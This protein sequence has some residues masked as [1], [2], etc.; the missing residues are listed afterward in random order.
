MSHIRESAEGEV[1]KRAVRFYRDGMFRGPYLLDVDGR[2]IAT[3]LKPSAFRFRLE[4]SF[5]DVVCE[6]R[7]KGIFRSRFE[8]VLDGRVIGEVRRESMWRR[9]VRVD[10]P[11]SWPEV[12]QAF[13]LW[14]GL[15][16][17][18]REAAASSG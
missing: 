15:I 10:L 9:S 12:L 2:T 17:W 11:D 14:L 6:L 3:A 7:K 4:I 18:K 8:L 5:G 16:M 1:D 13:V